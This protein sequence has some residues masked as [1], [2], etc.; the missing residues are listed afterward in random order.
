[1]MD[2]IDRALRVRYENAAAWARVIA[3]GMSADLSWRN[4]AGKYM[5]LYRS[6]TKA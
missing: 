6:L 3:N 5:E 4:S 1:M 2:A